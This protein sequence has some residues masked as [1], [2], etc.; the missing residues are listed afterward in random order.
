MTDTQP[1][2]TAETSADGVTLHVTGSATLPFARGLDAALDRAI[3]AIGRGPVQIDL[4][5]VTA[6]DGSGVVLVLGCQR[7]CQERF[8]HADIIGETP[9]ANRLLA[10]YRQ[11]HTEAEPIIG[12]RSRRRFFAGVGDSAYRGYLAV[13]ASCAFIGG[14]VRA[15]GGA[16]RQPRTVNWGEIPLLIQRAGAEG[17]A[18]V[19]MTN[20]LIGAI[21]AFQGALQLQRFGAMAMTP[22]MVT[23]AHVR[24]LGPIMTS[25]IV[26]GR[27]GAGFTAELG[28]MKVSEEVD[29]L[30]TMGLDP[31]RW[32]VLPRVI[33]LVIVLPLLTIIGNAVGLV[34]GM[35]ASLAMDPTMTF[36][37]YW[38]TVAGALEFRH[39]GSG[40]V[41]TVVFALAIAGL[42]CAQGLAARGG[43]AAVGVRTTAAVVLALFSVVVLDCVFAVFFAMVGI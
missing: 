34:G 26:A 42:A 5:G 20:L 22:L 6:I 36:G 24:E 41:K 10:L 32:L 40:V 8:E 4:A 1:N 16:I 38:D 2:V 18:I 11:R 12:Q 23:V 19:V 28:T 13:V 30:R 21:M 43:A 39:F 25:F 33:A 37:A 31:M 14:F 35:L 15:C 17:L 3:G 29:A 9:Q 7:R 27:S